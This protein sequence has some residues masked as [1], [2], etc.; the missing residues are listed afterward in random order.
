MILFAILAFSRR[1]KNT[2]TWAGHGRYSLITFAAG[3]VLGIL[4]VVFAKSAYG[5]VIERLISASYQQWYVVMG[6]A[7]I[8][9]DSYRRK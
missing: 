3:F 5:G 2:A 4:A 9:R 8:R 1:L 7:L 6:I